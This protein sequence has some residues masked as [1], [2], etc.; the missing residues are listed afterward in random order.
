MELVKKILNQNFK[1]IKKD[2]EEIIPTLHQAFT[3]YPSKKCARLVY[4][5]FMEDKAITK[6][7]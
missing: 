2:M 6:E 7:N 1:T 3:L 5:I 4:D